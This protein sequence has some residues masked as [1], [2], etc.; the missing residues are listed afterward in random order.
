[1]IQEIR[2]KYY[3]LSIANHVRKWVKKC[4]TW[5]KDKRID[6]SQ[7]TPELISRPEWDLGPEDVMQKDLLPELSTSVGY[8]NIITAFDI[9]SRYAFAY[10]VSSPTAVNTVNDFID[11]MTRCVYLPAVMITDKGSL[12]VSNVIL[13]IAEARGITLRHATTKHANY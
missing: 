3:F 13:E 2:Q 4:K 11:I 1:M 12:F 8:E 7:V 5:V 6:N 10:R 9:F